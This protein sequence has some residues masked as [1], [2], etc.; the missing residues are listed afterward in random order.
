M[1]Y[2]L[3]ERWHLNASVRWIDIDTEAEITSALGTTITVD[4]L[5]IDPWV[6]QLNIGYRF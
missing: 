3:T 2:A 6:Y 4:D 5:E 1:D